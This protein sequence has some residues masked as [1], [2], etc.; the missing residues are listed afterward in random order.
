MGEVFL[1][2]D[3]R[4]KRRVAVKRIRRDRDLQPALRQRLLRE[5]QAV[6]G[7]NHPAIV[8]VHDLIEDASGDCLVLEYV[9]GQT[10]AARLAGGPLEIAQ[11]LRL[12]AEIASGLAAAHAAGIVHRD[13]KPE[14]VIVTPAGHAKV[15]DF[16]LARM[17][18]AA[19]EILLTQQGTILGTY[20]TMSPEQAGGGEA[21]ER[22]DLFSLGVVLYEMLTGRSPF[23]GANP[24]E[25]LR[26][27]ISEHPPRVDSL[28]PGVPPR[29]AALIERLLAKEPGDRPSDAATV[30]REL[31]ALSS[32]SSSASQESVSDLPTIVAIPLDT[33]SRPLRR[34]PTA[35]A[36]TAGLSVLRGRR[37]AWQ[38]AMIAVLAV[39][40]GGG[41][42]LLHR[43]SE[44]PA[45]AAQAA[46]PKPLL[47]VVPRPQIDDGDDERLAL[48]ASG[49]LTA[50]LNALGSLEGVAAVDPLQ[51]VGSPK[52]AVDMARVA[53]ADEVLAASLEK[54]DAM[55]RI[56]LRRI[57]GTDGRVLWTDTFDAS[58]EMQDLRLLADVVGIH[59]RR[60]YPGKRQR[61]GMIAMN[62]RDEDYAAFLEVKQRLDAGTTSPLPEL[63][64]LERV[65]ETSPRFLEAR[66][67]AAEVSLSLFQSTKDGAYRDRALALID[68]AQELAPGDP[69]PFRT[70]FRI[71]LAENQ[72]RL[73]TLTLK[74]L[75]NL[76]PG[77][78]QILVLRANLAEREGRT[79]QAL[80]DLRTAADR[81]PSWRNLHQLADLEARSG[82]IDDARKHLGKIFSTSSGNLWAL[83]KLAGIE[84][85]FGDLGQAERIYLDLTARAP[86]S[87]YW[88]SVGV[89]RIFLGRFEDAIVAFRQALALDP[90]NAYTTLNLADAESGLGRTGAAEAHYRLALQ[91]LER[92]RPP[93]GLSLD[94]RMAQAQCLARLGRTREAVAITQGV[95]QESPDD[96]YLLQS[97]ALVYVLVGDRASA[98]VSAENALEKGVQRR[99]LTL[100]AFAPLQKDTEF[101]RLLDKSR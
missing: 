38:I 50:S 19:D 49:V 69:R 3:D 82:R 33:T 90:G 51:L 93:G 48:A 6:A 34:S 58:M 14:N 94:D 44:E 89:V 41:Y 17:R 21:D 66:I 79:E 24:L 70:R 74:Q 9:E 43:R 71:E 30:E 86:Q 5:A 32:S 11:A 83:E 67:L 15:L 57:Q 40:A 95:L 63:A 13:L 61:P 91:G 4:L 101:R 31:G 75:E 100:P 16:G 47:V 42:L 78:A 2:W 39:L 10:L 68:Q 77:D 98:L 80:A 88:N 60:G 12:A 62:V 99:W 45:K 26:R 59:L 22:S 56:T 20:H 87:R 85:V 81:V 25:V 55:G 64:R 46:P 97:A 72:P 84:L 28:R 27:V 8:Q 35:P 96:P 1:A 7:L 23:R 52:S 29:L 76:L 54:A 53:A 92:D 18:Q 73:A 37:F 65:I 36:S